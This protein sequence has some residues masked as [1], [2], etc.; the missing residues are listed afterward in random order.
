MERLGR[1]V[2]IPV[3]VRFV[4]GLVVAVERGTPLAEVLR[5]QA[6]DVREQRKRQLIEAGGRKEVLMLVPVVFLILPVVVLF[7]LYPGYFSLTQIAR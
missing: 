5:A 6:A 1:R 2:P 3:V 7:A 4:D